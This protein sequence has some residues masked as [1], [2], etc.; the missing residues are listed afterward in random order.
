[1]KSNLNLSI[2]LFGWLAVMCG[3]IQTA[4]AEE[5][6]IRADFSGGNV[7]V[8]KIEGN[9]V[10]IAPD[11]RGGKPWFYWNF[12][13]EAAKPGRVRF[14]F[15]AEAGDQMS[16]NGPAV[17]LDEGKTWKWL[18]AEQVKFRK[19]GADAKLQPSDEFAF[20][21][22][23]PLQKVRFSVGIPYLQSNLDKFIE[24]IGENPHLNRDI[25]TRSRNGRRF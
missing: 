14:V 6:K 12:E 19:L 25:L 4:A 22:T 5:I 20:E 23:A 18:G 13:A 1:M 2:R 7:L 24:S 10:H 11:L 17:S 9:T 8:Q 15:P 21:F 16:V 3:F